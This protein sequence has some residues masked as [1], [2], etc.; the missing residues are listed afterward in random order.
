MPFSDAQLAQAHE[1]AGGSFFA[2]DLDAAHTHLSALHCD[3]LRLW[4]ACKANPLSAVLKTVGEAGFSFDVASLGELEQVL[5]TGAAGKNILLTGP[6]KNDR[7]LERAMGVGV[8]WF[9]VESHEQLGRLQAL[10]ERFN[11]RVNA[12]IRLQLSWDK[13]ES[14]VLGG[15]KITP[16]GM[17][18]ED[19]G[20]V[21]SRTH[22]AIRGVHVFQ[23]GNIES[24]RAISEIWHRIANEARSFAAKNDFPLDVLDLGGGLGISYQNPSQIFPW[25]EARA[26]LADLRAISGAGELWLELGRYAIGPFGTYVTQILEKKT[27]K[28]EKFLLCSGGSHHLVRPALVGESFPARLLASSSAE[29]EDFHVHGPLCTALDRLGTYS[30]PNSVKVGDLLALTQTGAYGF[31]ESM[32]FFLCHDLPGEIILRNGSVRTIREVESPATWM[33]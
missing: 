11:R 25:A 21:P 7:F 23:W 20:M 14:S 33:R 28:G 17:G 10:G 29:M 2:Y 16:F 30:L 32:P 18:A 3:G 13:V 31:T 9:V 19:W 4:Y 15:A 12:L 8:E 26:L 27:V 5:Q 6:V 1:A 24:V 22:V